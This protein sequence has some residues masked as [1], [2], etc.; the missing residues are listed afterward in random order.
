MTDLLTKIPYLQSVSDTLFLSTHSFDLDDVVKAFI[1]SGNFRK[2]CS[3][4]MSGFLETEFEFEQFRDILQHCLPAKPNATAIFN[5]IIEIESSSPKLSSESI[6]SISVLIECIAQSETS[7][8][9]IPVQ[10]LLKSYISKVK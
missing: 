9:S 1:E 10:T 7:E 3:L 2:L 4:A 6:E 5:A 8:L